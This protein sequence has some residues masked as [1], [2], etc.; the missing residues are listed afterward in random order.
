MFFNNLLVDERH[1]RCTLTGLFTVG[2]KMLTN[3]P[4]V[5]TMGLSGG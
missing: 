2:K 4:F 3:T 5:L 1:V